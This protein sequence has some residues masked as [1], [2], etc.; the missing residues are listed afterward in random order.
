MTPPTRR[1]SKFRAVAAI[2]LALVAILGIHAAGRVASFCS[3]HRVDSLTYAVAAHRFWQPAPGAAAV[4]PDKPP[5][6]A[7]LTGWVF[8]VVSGEP[9]R[10]TL[11]A[12]ESG[13]MLAAYALFAVVT[14]RLAGGAAAVVATIGL[15][16]GFNYYNAFDSTTDGFN[17]AEN[18][19]AAPVVLAVAGHL[20]VRSAGVGGVLTG[21]GLGLALAI[22]QTALAVTAAVV[23]HSFYD[24]IVTRSV[25]A[26]GV[27]LEWTLFGVIVAWLPIVVALQQRGLLERQ[28]RG[29]LE[30]SRAHVA[31]HAPSWP[32]AAM[33]APLLPLLLWILVGGAASL[34]RRAPL[35]SVEP[36]SSIQ[37]SPLAFAVIWCAC[38]AAMAS[39]MT[40]PAEHYLQ[41]VVLP[42]AL[43]AAFG[44]RATQ[45]SLE[46][47]R[48]PQRLRARACLGIVAVCIAVS[49]ATPILSMARRNGPT[50]DSGRERMLFDDALRNAEI[51]P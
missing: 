15:V 51:P 31:L 21:V 8:R 16:I 36:S 48:R 4:V 49:A 43:L 18:Y 45:R 3:P 5:G 50:F 20:C 38:E 41:L 9:S 19:L 14:F 32:T 2:A 39:L 28:V 23:V 24:A 1:R 27:R 22:K 6:Q 10:T 33:V 26:R 25:R 40:K 11:I 44:V 46:L 30:H 37:T 47:S 17:L 12:V 7:V 34:T 29:L 13:A 42:A 35:G